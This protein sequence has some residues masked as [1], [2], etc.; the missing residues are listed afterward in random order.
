MTLPRFRYHPDPIGSGSVIASEATC[1]CC[2]QARG[3]IYDGPVYTEEDDVDA[4]CPWCIASG[5]AHE[6]FDASFVDSEAFP[7][8]T[9]DK[10][11][12]EI[13]ERTP[14]FSAWQGERWPVC[15]DD[16]TAFL[17]PAGIAE[18]RARYR[19]LEGEVLSHIIYELQVSGGAAL[20]MLESLRADESPTAFLFQ[21][22]HCERQHFYL[23][24]S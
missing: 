19:S 5:D 23:D 16:A 4:I 20:R 6:M 18:I 14:G 10:A 11:I 7:E 17:M 1:K 9:P 8:G 15:C 24:G 3:F 2:D 21:C 22:L 12:D 13:V